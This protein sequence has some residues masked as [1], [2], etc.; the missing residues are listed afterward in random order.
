MSDCFIMYINSLVSWTF[1]SIKGNYKQATTLYAG[2]DTFSMASHPQMDYLIFTY[3]SI[4]TL[5]NLHIYQKE[6]IFS[7]AVCHG[8]VTPSSKSAGL[9]I[10]IDVLFVF[11]DNIS[12]NI[13]NYW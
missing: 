9:L 11:C 2:V 12:N 7:N 13:L 10:L 8:I 5:N 6:N 3:Q 1:H 4:S